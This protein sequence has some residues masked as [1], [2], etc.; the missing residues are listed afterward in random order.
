MKYNFYTNYKNKL[1]RNDFKMSRNI[2]ITGTYK[3][4]K[5]NS[6]GLHN[7]K[8]SELIESKF[9]QKELKELKE[10]YLKYFKGKNFKS[11][12][13]N[14]NVSNSFG[15]VF[16]CGKYIE[17]NEDNYSKVIVDYFYYVNEK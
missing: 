1:K 9:T 4:N 7:A 3:N 13:L 10:K 16:N 5:T 8:N 17:L 15:N 12:N 14:L 2:L 6:I 11:I